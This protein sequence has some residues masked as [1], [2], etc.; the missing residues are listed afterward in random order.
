MSDSGEAGELA[1]VHVLVV[2][3]DPDS[4]DMMQAALNYAGALVTAVASARA[5]TVRT[6]SGKATGLRRMP[7]KPAA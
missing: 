5:A 2:D 7:M 1:G 3:D 6:R 4:L